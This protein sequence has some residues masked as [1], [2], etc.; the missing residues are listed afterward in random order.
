M[1]IHL[2]ASFCS[3]CSCPVVMPACMRHTR[4]AKHTGGASRSHH[5]RAPP[6]SPP[7]NPPP[8]E[9]CLAWPQRSTRSP[10]LASPISWL[11]RGGEQQWWSKRG[12]GALPAVEG[13]AHLSTTAA[14]KRAWRAAISALGRMLGA[15]ARSTAHWCTPSDS[16]ATL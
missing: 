10:R 1:A 3:V 8:S 6:P 2:A 7:N 4:V 13:C 15:T 12:A 9:N 16:P 14:T 5:Q 11:R